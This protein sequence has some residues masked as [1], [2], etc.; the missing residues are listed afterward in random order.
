MLNESMKIQMQTTEKIF[1]I[2]LLFFRKMLSFG[3]LAR[4]ICNSQTL[5]PRFN[6]VM[7][8]TCAERKTLAANPC[9]RSD[10]CTKRQEHTTAVV[11]YFTLIS[12]NYFADSSDKE[13]PEL[14]LVKTQLQKV[15]MDLSFEDLGRDLSLYKQSLN[16]DF[17]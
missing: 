13:M 15:I 7:R 14:S 4:S 11:D 6:M 12:D 16:F 10:T 2:I 17:K 8:G 3:R 1:V 5:V 9:D